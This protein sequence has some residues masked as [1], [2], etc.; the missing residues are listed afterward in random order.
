[1]L[2]APIPLSFPLPDPNN[3]PFLE[4][5]LSSKAIALITGNKRHFPKK[6]YGK[7]RVLSPG[8]FFEVFGKKL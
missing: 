2:A 5:A 8:E 1:M 7:T 6:V 4:T 3:E